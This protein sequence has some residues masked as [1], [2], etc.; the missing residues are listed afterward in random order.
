MRVLVQSFLKF[1]VL[2]FKF[3]V[4]SFIPIP[5]PK[6]IEELSFTSSAEEVNSGLSESYKN[7]ESTFSTTTG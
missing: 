6:L 5:I 4:L 2:S 1:Q 3:Q 7:T